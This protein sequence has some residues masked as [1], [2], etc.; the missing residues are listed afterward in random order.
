MFPYNKDNR[1]TL[2]T[3]LGNRPADMVIK[4]GTLMDVYTGR[5]I[6]NRSVA[7][8]GSWIAYVGPDAENTVGKETRVIEADG[9]LLAPGYIDSHTHM[10]N[11]CDLANIL[12]Y[13]I[14][15]GTTSIITEVET[16]GISMGIEGFEIFLDQVR[17]R[18]IKLFCL[19]PPMISLSPAL[20]SRIITRDQA[21]ELLKNEYVIGL[22]E[23]YWQNAIL[24]PDDRVLKLMQ[25]TLKVGK[26]VQGHSAGASDKKLA[27]YAAAGALSCHE[28]I[29]PE[30]VMARLEM[31]LYNIVREGH[32]RHDLK[33]L[34]PL[35]GKIDL[36]RCTLCTDGA[37]P[38]ELVTDG[39]LVNVVQKAVDMGVPAMDALRMVTLN[40]A[41][42]FGLDYLLGGI[43]P[44]RLADILVLPKP[45][46]M[47]PDIVV[48][49]GK[50]LVDEGKMTA[51]VD[52]RPF[53]EKILN[54][55]HVPH[56][57]PTDFSVTLPPFE[58]TI[59]T[60]DIQSNGL[61]SREGSAR[62]H[63]GQPAIAADP[64]NDLLK[65]AFVESVSGNGEMFTG[66]VRGWGQKRGAVA[67]S[68]AWDSAGIVGIGADDRDI[69]AAFNK[70]IDMQGGIAFSLDG[71][72]VHQIPYPIG[73]FTSD[74]PILELNKKNS[75]LRRELCNLG[76][77]YDSP[78]L[79]LV[80][81]T[82]AAIPF[83]RITEKGYFRFRENDYVGV[84]PFLRHHGPIG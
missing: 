52:K 56:V 48:S 49:E 5:I 79:T 39:Y 41:E 72:I 55:V 42:H 28:S 4:N 73:A 23:S 76:V 65:L 69:A 61:V 35:I 64:D 16:Y 67:T 82:A 43:S 2:E 50:L 53:P 21:E 12:P 8:A 27:A 14:P 3:A 13:I 29:S 36:R 38:E 44:G 30:D 45:G 17:D 20:D 19:I 9:R 78:V 66:F 10:A 84:R 47:K 59:R 63:S 32:I 46:V 18:P 25:E 31:G 75:A 68:L 22:G 70:V 77:M 6:P 51:H 80:V 81:L 1:K 74:L 37:D 33:S 11:Y 57:A 24:T 15:G 60:I 54:T 83:I 62:V 34:I 40:P 26:S 58:D 7:I 71:G